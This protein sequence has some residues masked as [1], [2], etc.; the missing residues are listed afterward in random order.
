MRRVSLLRGAAKSTAAGITWWLQPVVRKAATGFS[1]GEGVPSPVE[2]DAGMDG[3]LSPSPYGKV[4]GGGPAATKQHFGLWLRIPLCART[5][6]PSR[7]LPFVPIELSALLQAIERCKSGSGNP[8]LGKVVR[9][10]ELR[11]SLRH[12]SRLPR[13]VRLKSACTV[14]TGAPGQAH[15]CEQ[16]GVELEHGPERA[17]PC[18]RYFDRAMAPSGA[19]PA[20]P[21]DSAAGCAKESRRTAGCPCAML[22]AISDLRN[23]KSFPQR[24][25]VEHC[26]SFVLEK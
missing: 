14:L 19:A 1:W 21:T 20:A 11:A 5:P 9:D 17:T 16:F 23:C 13:P 25:V 22:R 10:P 2:P 12:S 8:S 18:L 24:C 3:R 4:V 15:N 26:R 7:E 6:S